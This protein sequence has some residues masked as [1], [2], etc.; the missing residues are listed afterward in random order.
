MRQNII[1]IIQFFD[2]H[3]Y[4]NFLRIFEIK[5]QKQLPASR[6]NL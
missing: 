2:F 4:I 1:S 6:N 5:T 3:M